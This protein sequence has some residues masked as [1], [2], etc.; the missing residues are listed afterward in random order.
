MGSTRGGNG[1]IGPGHVPDRK[2]FLQ[3]GTIEPSRIPPGYRMVGFGFAQVRY[4]QGFNADDMARAD[5][6][7]WVAVLATPPRPGEA[8]T[9]PYIYHY[10]V[11][12]F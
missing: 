12:D 3:R 9:P 8:R 4:A 6:Y 5:R 2:G 11:N 10:P 1:E 7:H